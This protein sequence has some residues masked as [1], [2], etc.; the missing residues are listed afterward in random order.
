MR[1]T[2]AGT[3]TIG[4]ALVANVVFLH[5]L[6]PGDHVI[7]GAVSFVGDGS[8]ASRTTCTSAEHIH[9]GRGCRSKI[10]IGLLIPFRRISSMG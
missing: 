4:T 1:T 6:R 7:E 3:G 2:G 5:P 9:A 10:L 8:S